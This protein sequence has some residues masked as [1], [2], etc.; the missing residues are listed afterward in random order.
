MARTRLGRDEVGL[1]HSDELVILRPVLTI[2]SSVPA[3]CR[4]SKEVDLWG[5][6]AAAAGVAPGLGPGVAQNGH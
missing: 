1:V 5:V 3:C 4:A 6:A 2:T